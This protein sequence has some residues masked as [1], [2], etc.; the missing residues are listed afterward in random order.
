MNI[1]N[2]LYAQK[3]DHEQT[4]ERVGSR[5]T[6]ENDFVG[7]AISMA[8]Q[9]IETQVEGLGLALQTVH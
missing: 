6:I 4:Q 8:K 7:S 3:D 9:T 2:Y 5:D 1:L